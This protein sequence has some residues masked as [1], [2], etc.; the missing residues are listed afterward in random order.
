MPNTTNPLPPLAYQ[1]AEKREKRIITQAERKPHWLIESDNLKALKYLQE[2]FRGS[3]HCMIVDPPYNTKRG[4]LNYHDTFTSSEDWIEFMKPRL[5][6]AKKLLHEEGFIFLHIDDNEAFS[7]KVIC[8]EIFGVENYVASFP[9]ITS[10]KPIEECEMDEEILVSGTNIGQIRM[11]HEYI[12]CYRKSPK[13]KLS[14]V[15]SSQ[16]WIDSRITNAKNP[17]SQLTLPKGIRCEEAI[18]H[19]F[20]NEVGGKSEPLKILN[21][22]GMRIENGIL[23][24]D[25]LLEASFRNPQIIKKLIEGE[26]VMD[27]KGQEFDEIFLT[28]TGIPYT[29]KQK[30]GDIPSSV[31]SGYGDTSKWG[32]QIKEM[33][34]K[35][36][37]SFM[38]PKPYPLTK[39]LIQMA[40]SCKEA[41]IM[42]FFAGSGTT[43]HAV[44]ELNADDGGHR[45]CIL[46]TNN[47]NNICEE[48][49]YVRLDKVIH[50]YRTPKGRK[51]KGIGGNLLYFELLE[52][53]RGE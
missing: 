12:L 47:E 13:A 4:D 36:S 23:Q 35:D 10:T 2:P 42:D 31:F 43:A 34:G 25:V 14:L 27:K 33:V 9:W 30:L 26:K 46:V 18:T 51:A 48:I 1:L 19:T 41:V 5:Q 50:G 40:T 28:K 24:N 22:E 49:T 45:Q 32:N 6:L 21:P 20:Y 17:I 29:R 44:L 7:L 16:K 37:I 53:H 52:T 38:Y 15:P 39:K 3:V 8:N 11:C